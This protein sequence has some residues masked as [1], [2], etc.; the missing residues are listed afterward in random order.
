M[1]DGHRKH[2]LPSRTHFTIPSLP[3]P[4]PAPLPFAC[5]VFATDSVP[6]HRMS[7]SFSFFNRWDLGVG[8]V[9]LLSIPLFSLLAVWINGQRPTKK[10]DAMFALLD[11]ADSLLTTCSQ[12]GLIKDREAIDLQN[13]LKLY[14]LS[15]SCIINRKTHL[16]LCSHR[17]DAETVSQK[18]LC[19]TT[20]R[21]DFINVLRGL[22]TRINKICKNVTTVRAEISVCNLRAALLRFKA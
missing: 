12:D 20:L 16:Y 2:K 3:S 22:T 14:V 9:G 7:D 11:S 1:P 4:H 13:K 15:I 6:S 5:Q 19:V 10:L 21:E 18:A 8:I 17:K